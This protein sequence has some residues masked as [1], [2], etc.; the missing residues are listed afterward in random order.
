[1]ARLAV[2]AFLLVLAIAFATAFAPAP[3]HTAERIPLDEG[4]EF[5][6]GGPDEATAIPPDFE[7]RAVSVPHDWSIELSTSPDASTRGGGGYFPAGKGWYR[8]ALE[9]PPEWRGKD[10]SIHFEGVYRNAVVWLN[11]VR[12]GGHA[13]GYTPFRFSLT[14]DLR[15]DRPNELLV[16]V[17]NEPQPNS[18]WYTGSGLYRPVWLE[19]RPPV[20]FAPDSV[21]ATTRYLAPDEAIVDVG[22]VV[23]SARQLTGEGRVEFALFAPDGTEVASTSVAVEGDDAATTVAVAGRLTVGD[24]LVWTPDA[25]RLYT[26]RATLRRGQEMLEQ[27]EETTGLRTLRWSAERGF[28]LNG[29]PIEL[30][31]GNVHHDHGPLGA[32]AWPEA[33]RRKAEILKAAGFNAV[34]T[35]HNPPSEAFLHACDRLGLLVIDEAFDGWKVRKVDHDYSRIFDENWENDLRAMVLRDRNHPSVVMWSIGN[36]VYERGQDAGIERA[37]AMAAVIR[38]L[39]RS[40]PVTIGLN[41]LGETGDWT[42]LDAIFDALDIAGYN[43]ELARHEEDHRRRP[44][45]VVYAAESYAG[46]AF[47]SFRIAHAHPYVIGDFV[48][49]A[50]DYLGEAGIGRVFPPGEP[51]R[52]HW[53]GEH[54]PWHGAAS[55][56]IDLIGTR[57]PISH[58]RNIVWDRGEA[59]YAAVLVPAPE[60]GSWN[61]TKWSV[62]PALSSWTWPGREGEAL[63]LEVY[64]RHPSVRVLLNGELVGEAPTTEAEAFKARFTIPFEPGRLEVVGGSET[65]T[66]QTAGAPTRLRFVETGPSRRNDRLRFAVVEIQDGQGIRHPAADRPIRFSVT[67]EGRIL[68]VGSGDVTSTESY[69]ANPRRS[70]QGRALVVVEADTRSRGRILLEAEAEGL[71]PA[72]IRLR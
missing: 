55:G 32:A 19:I 58:Y 15:F 64:S 12:L 70:Y 65:F 44:N 26:L 14:Q 8:T 40:R 62:P 45:R 23:T 24:P 52:P 51:A 33:E 43:Y 63:T 28:E 13:Y 5:H 21:F 6:L 47:E 42:R 1:M 4:W 10:V 71:E 17:A 48:W 22:A 66:L 30:F 16:H 34:R 54:Y 69:R 49:S 60:G 7:W 61:L 67:G 2:Q 53:I 68:A 20:H 29:E 57:K 3:A 27:A 39:D 38:Q 59:L 18:R 37:H 11:G 41:G 25:P 56:D 72:R 31:G 50:L 36:E 46:D 9:A 35:A